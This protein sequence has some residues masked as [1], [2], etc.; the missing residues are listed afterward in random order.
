[1]IALV[2]AASLSAPNVILISVDTL[3]ADHLGFYG[4][5][6]ATSPNLDRL[7][8]ESL[9]FD[10]MVCE[11]PLTGPSF[12][13]MMTSRFPRSTGVTRNGIR[14][15]EDVP[16]TAERF[17]AAGYETICVTSNWTLKSKLSGLDRGF[18]VYDDGFRKRRWV[19]LKSERDAKDVTDI[20]VEQLQ[21][22]DNARPLFAWFHYSDP[23]APYKY[24]DAFKVSTP[25]DYP[26]DPGAEE[27][28]R[29]DSEIAYTDA[30]IQR[31]VS[32]LP[33]GETYI[34]FVGDHGES[35]R[36]HDYLGHGRRMYQNN[37]HIPLFI[38]GP[39]LAPGRTSA[40]A[41]GIDLGPTL[42]S[43][44]GLDPVDGMIGQALLRT[45]IDPDRLRVVETYGGAVLNLPGAREIMESMGPELQAVVVDGWKLIEGNDDVELY[46]LPE[47]PGELNNLAGADRDRVARLKKVIASWADAVTPSESE[48]ADL[49]EEDIE[50][51]RSLG[52]VD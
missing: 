39:G 24:H 20:A 22:R 30:Q 48:E 47:D 14:L 33:M 2:L 15:P 23:H 7:A 38:H 18:G 50:A 43:L 34:V 25:E 19:V 51:L 13:A 41:R 40:P 46:Y 52:Y 3:R 29:Y 31:L 37:L 42:L 27:K 36:E 12:T 26:D 28:A 45:D 1:M 11:V 8:K 4:H 21:A 44:A 6:V 35:L 9:V 49:D 5:T 10:D 32:A 16:T 17:A